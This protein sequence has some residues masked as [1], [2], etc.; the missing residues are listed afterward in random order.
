[1]DDIKFLPAVTVGAF[2]GNIVDG[3]GDGELKREQYKLDR[4]E[5]RVKLRVSCCMTYC[6]G[7]LVGDCVLVGFLV[8][9]GLW[10][11]ILVGLLLKS[12]LAKQMI[13]HKQK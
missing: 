12:C 9:V 3:F 11:G 4:D 10:V 1:M 13:S 5:Q 8:F 2:V 7:Y 6:V